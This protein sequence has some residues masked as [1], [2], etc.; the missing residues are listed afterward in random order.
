MASPTRRLHAA[1]AA[2]LF[3]VAAA[4]VLAA[5]YA[6]LS[7]GG[8]PHTLTVFDA[9]ARSVVAGPVSVG[10]YHM[11]AAVSADGERLFALSRDANTASIGTLTVISVTTGQVETSFAVGANPQDVATSPDGAKIYVVNSG[12]RTLSIIDARTYAVRNVPLPMCATRVA[13]SPDSRYVYVACLAQVARFDSQ[14]NSIVGPIPLVAGDAVIALAPSPDGGVLYALAVT[15][16]GTGRLYTIAAGAMTISWSI[17]LE[18]WPRA[19]AVNPDGRSVYVALST[20]AA[21]GALASINTETAG[22]RGTLPIPEG[23]RSIGV[24]ADGRTAYVTTFVGPVHIVDLENG[25]VS[26]TLTA[27]PGYEQIVVATGPLSRIVRR[28]IVEF[29]HE[30]LDHYFMT[31]YA[32]EIDDLDRG[33]HTGWRRTGETFDALEPGRSRGAGGPVCRFYG[34]PS[35]GLDSHFYSGHRSE[36]DAVGRRF[37]DAWELEA[38]RVFDVTLPNLVTGQCPFGTVPVF[39]LWNGRTDSNHRYTTS[40]ALWQAM[41][42]QG[43]IPEGYGNEGVAMCAMAPR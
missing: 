21:T 2:I 33:V 39:R 29:Y 13:V 28:T 31:G 27:T 12:D 40:R 3:A 32:N 34:K 17:L 11:A 20:I 37:G 6:Y 7:S 8:S 19:L 1:F 35:A 36:C 26:G 4:P 9:E 43:F 38:Y 41:R 23:P 5:P 30:R 18:Q 15:T 10:D 25:S 24:S 14:D 42:D 16:S 22:R